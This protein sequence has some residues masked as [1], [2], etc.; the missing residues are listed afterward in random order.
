MTDTSLQRQSAL[1]KINGQILAD[2]IAPELAKSATQLV[3]G[4]GDPMAQ[5]VFIGEAPGAKEDK[6]GEPFMGASGRL[7]D[8]M[9]ASINLD[10]RDVYIT[11]IVKYRP[12]SNRDPLS[13][14]IIAFTP[15]L[16]AQIEIIRPRLIIFLGR[17]AMNVFLPKL[18]ISEVHGIV[19]AR[20]NFHYLPLFH[21]AAA[22]YN[23]KM[24][25]VL[26]EDF[27]KIPGLLVELD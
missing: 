25:S 24:R 22:L 21:P 15:Y 13:S 5:L 16:K 19:I 2:G 6:V 14:E 11:N 4:S 12:P 7:L 20:D 10:R 1:D 23:P 26:L 27:A 8:E 3:F 17:H 9:L 18:V